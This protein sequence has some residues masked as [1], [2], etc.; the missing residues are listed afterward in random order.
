MRRVSILAFDGVQSLDP[1][2]VATGFAGA[3][4]GARG[5]LEVLHT[6][7]GYDVRVV[8]ATAALRTSS[9]VGL[10]AEPLDDG[11][12]DTLLVAGGIGVADVPDEVVAWVR[13]AAGRARRVASVCTGAFLLARAGLLDGRAATTHWASCSRLARTFPA[14]RVEKGPLVVRDGDV[15][16]SAGVL[17]GVDLALAIVEEDL[18]AGAAQDVARYLVALRRPG[19][20]P[21]APVR[22][23]LREL[24]SWLPDHL[25]ADLSVPALAARAFMS[26][27]HFARAWR[28][29][30]GVT[31]AAY[32]E[33]LRVERARALL[34]GGAT[35]EAA[36]RASGFGSAETLRRACHRRAGAAPREAA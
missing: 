4:V 30:T 1:T 19:G 16:T 15:L 11:P 10:A 25:D 18:G 8:A 32:V 9:G 36:A 35:V 33:A 14:V 29:E 24:Q 22:E 7:R 3:G 31:P 2:N 23:P 17:A 6:A 27:R 28:R 26:P 21:L 20:Q 34:R 5:P 12:L 13:G